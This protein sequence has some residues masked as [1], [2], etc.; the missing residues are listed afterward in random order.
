MN[1]QKHGG[2]LIFEQSSSEILFEELPPETKQ[3]AESL[4]WEQRRHLLLLCHLLCVAPPEV[5][6]EFLDNYTADGLVSRKLQDT[7]TE[8]RVKTHFKRFAINTELNES[9]FRCYIKQFYIHSAQDVRNQPNLYFKLVFRLILNQE[10]QNNIL[11]Y[12]LGFEVLKL[13]FQ[14]SWL[15][16]ER[17]Y[18]LQKNQEDFIN[19]YIKPIQNAHKINGI[20]VPEKQKTFFAKRD[21]FVKVPNLKPKKLIELVMATFTTDV[22]INLGFSI[23]RDPKFL[24][25]DHGYIFQPEPDG[26][27]R[28]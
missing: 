20:I 26:I 15:Q 2:G 4:P 1:G 6:A 3:W 22:V 12:V 8:Y 28:E 14:M 23:I 24:V 5:Q 9:V 19:L 7:H 17:L 16:H 13:M 18:Q 21:H 27:F 25:F 11:S 10:E